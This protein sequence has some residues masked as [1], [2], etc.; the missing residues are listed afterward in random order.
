VV[1]L[2]WSAL[3]V[4]G[5][6]ETISNQIWKVA[7]RS[8]VRKFT[9]Y[10]AIL[11][12]GPLLVIISSSMNIYITAHVAAFSHEFPLLRVASPVVFIMLK[13]LPYGLIWVVFI[14][15]YLVIPNTRVKIISAVIGGFV[16][17]AVFQP[18]QGGYMNVQVLLSRYNAIYGSFAALPL[19]L[20]WLQL[21]WI[22][23]LFGAQLA[24]AHQHVGRHAVAVDYSRI[25][26]GLRKKYALY[27]YWAL[28]HRFRKGRAPLPMPALAERLDLPYGIVART[29]DILA[30][31]GLVSAVVVH[32][33][34]EMGYQPAM[35]INT[36]S[37]SDVLQALDSVGD[38]VVPERIGA[39]FERI[40]DTVETLAKGVRQSPAD[41]LVKDI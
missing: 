14:L 35:D 28:V 36:I 2:F 33:Q 37:V 11:I 6:I 20:I 17:G 19:L 12:I 7:S 41:R 15:T 29:I 1:L 13:I 32:S 38:D 31:C 4:L 40:F 5:R 16:A 27:I 18:L 39:D 23:V 10:L 26:I 21:S 30:G 24:Y 34:E 9:D 22:I 3:K 25:S 8:M